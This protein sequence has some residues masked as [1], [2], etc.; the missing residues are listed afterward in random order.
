MG[1]IVA[2]TC[3]EAYLERCY[4]RVATGVE[5][6]LLIGAVAPAADTGARAYVVAAVPV[7]GSGSDAAA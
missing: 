7:A 2:D 1:D 4:S 5:V 6:G 3:V